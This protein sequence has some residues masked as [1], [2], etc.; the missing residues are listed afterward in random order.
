MK[1]N[2][3]GKKFGSQIYSLC[4]VSP[5]GVGKYDNINTG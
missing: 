3:L 5:K 2:K 1:K 4:F